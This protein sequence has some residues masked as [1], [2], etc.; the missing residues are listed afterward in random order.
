MYRR[1]GTDAN[2]TQRGEEA[3][4]EAGYT[5]ESYVQVKYFSVLES[6]ATLL[7]AIRNEPTSDQAALTDVLERWARAM[8]PL[9]RTLAAYGSSEIEP[10]WIHFLR[11]FD[12]D[13]RIR[14]LRLT[15]TENAV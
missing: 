9:P 5:Y 3:A 7:G 13:F 15:L 2:E 8:F 4:T 1:W 10:A 14:R 6:L 12:L 11:S